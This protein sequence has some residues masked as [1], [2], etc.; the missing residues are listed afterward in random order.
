MSKISFVS[1]CIEYYSDY[2]GKPSNEIYKLFKKE[3][4]LDVLRS[5]YDDLHGMSMEYMVDY[6][7]QYLKGAIK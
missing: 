2:V 5:D 1:F 7:N 3:G 4:L 6:C